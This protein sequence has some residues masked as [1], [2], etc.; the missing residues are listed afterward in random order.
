MCCGGFTNIEVLAYRHPES[1]QA[2]FDHTNACPM[3]GSRS[4]SLA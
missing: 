2:L 4:V 1:G 3:R